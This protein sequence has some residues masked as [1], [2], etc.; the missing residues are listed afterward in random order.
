MRK[1]RKRE[2]L[3]AIAV[4]PEV[5]EKFQLAARSKGFTVSG[6]IRAALEAEGYSLSRQAQS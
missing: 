1:V 4:T 3:L 5:Q 6:A 2:R